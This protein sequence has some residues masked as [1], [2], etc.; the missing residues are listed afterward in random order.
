MSLAVANQYAK[1]L[2]ETLSKP[3]AAPGPEEALLQLESFEELLKVAPQFRTILLSPAVTS[4]QKSK[5]ITRIGALAGLSPVMVRFLSVVTKHRRIPLL[6]SIRQMFRAQVDEQLGLTRAEITAARA[7]KDEQKLALETKLT[8]LV[9][10]T[11]RCAFAEDGALLG[12]LTVR[13]G[14][15]VLDGSVRGKLES[16]RHRLEA[17]G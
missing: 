2:L 17:E 5:A 12:G 8:A 16:L 3:G 10:H 14:S 6:G 1:A 7:M 15:K 9:G 4:G 11:V 13:I